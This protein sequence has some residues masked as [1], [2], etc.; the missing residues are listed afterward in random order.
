MPVQTDKLR[1]MFDADSK[2]LLD[3]LTRLVQDLVAGDTSNEKI[4]RAFRD[5][6]SIKSEAGFLE[7][8][9]VANAAHRLEE[10]LNAMRSGGGHT[11]RVGTSRLSGDLERLAEEIARYHS[12]R[13]AAPQGS[14]QSS[15]EEPVG[16]G[17]TERGMLREARS[18]GEK[19]FRV[20]VRI[21]CEPEFLYPRAFLVVNNLELECGVV[22]TT[23]ALDSMTTSGQR[24][25]TVLLT[26]AGEDRTVKR[27]LNVD[28][29]EI[30]EISEL[31]FDEVEQIAEQA[32]E[33][34]V[35]VGLSGGDSRGQEETLLVADEVAFLSEQSDRLAGET[36]A[37]PEETTAVVRRLRSYAR[38]LKSAVDRTARVQ[39]LD[40]IRELREQSVA[41]AAKDG[42]RVRFLVGGSG[43]VVSP[44]VA[45]ALTE[46][47][48]HL[49][50]NSIDHG[51]EP[52]QQRAQRGR[53][54]AGT[55]KI[56][57]DQMGESIRIRVTD[58]G[59]GID[60]KALR[61]K[62]G[63]KERSL[64][65]MLATPGFSMRPVADHSSG[66]GVGLDSVV[67]TVRNLLSGGIEMQSQAGRG[68]V[69]SIS[70]PS[71]KQL[72]NVLVADSGEGAAA[73]PAAMVVEYRALMQRRLKRDSFGGSYYDY[74]GQSL[75]LLTLLGG[76]PAETAVGDGSVGI[77]VSA[78]SRRAVL[79]C[80]AILAA[81]SVVRDETRR[82]HVYSRSVGREIPFVFP[83]EIIFRG[84]QVPSWQSSVEKQRH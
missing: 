16:L 10:S 46:A 22:Q 61:E 8:S 38:L 56:T 73:V 29:V 59:T 18:R 5:A 68:T 50:R 30:V 41:H 11:E 81:E 2:L 52:I 28:E 79:L 47:L 34:Q 12:T 76:T 51:I 25:V 36:G 71:G 20:V 39:L 32:P 7:L 65:D 37:D 4:D 74:E 35:P 84:Q 23:P 48:L 53:P 24:V 33:M 58:D 9:D 31:A 66:R 44:A 17:P 40:A 26:T 60:E 42:K 77:V 15:A 19:L 63:D 49:V 75:P 82:K 78:G 70:V 62:T 57:V 80:D 55:V 83:P 13:E 1:R 72:V 21:T 64:V 43:A 6:H 27:L 3:S 45:D 54:P 14:G 67:H 69:V